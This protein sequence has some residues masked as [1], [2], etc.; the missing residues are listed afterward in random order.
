MS[1]TAELMKPFKATSQDVGREVCFYEDAA[2]AYEALQARY[3]RLEKAAGVFVAEGPDG[4]PRL[5]KDITLGQGKALLVALQ[6]PSTCPKCS[7]TLS[8]AE[9]E[10]VHTCSSTAMH[11]TVYSD[12][13]VLCG[14]RLPC[15]VHGADTAPTEDK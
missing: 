13:E 5:Q 2:N 15:P 3:E 1:E 14:H 6:Q 7:K 10:S 11:C 4:L 12:E 8:E 9:I